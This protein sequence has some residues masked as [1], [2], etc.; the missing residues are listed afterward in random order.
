MEWKK[1]GKYLLFQD[2]LVW[3]SLSSISDA[4][5]FNHSSTLLEQNETID[6]GSG[7]HAVV[8]GSKAKKGKASCIT[9]IV[10]AEGTSDNRDC[11]P[12]K[13]KN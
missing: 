11:V 1:N 2:L 3:A 8:K 9:R 13:S 5:S 4:K 7:K 6:E 12:T 10:A